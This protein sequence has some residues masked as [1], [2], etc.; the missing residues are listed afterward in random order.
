MGKLDY[1][2]V[3]TNAVGEPANPGLIS[4][5]AICGV[6]SLLVGAITFEVWRESQLYR[7]SGE[8][9]ASLLLVVARPIAS[10]VEVLLLGFYLAFVSTPK[11]IGWVGIVSGV[12][13]G[14][15]IVAITLTW[16]F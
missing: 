4:L 13:T 7:H 8:N 1:R 3:R 10:L 15:A 2:R 16:I 5:T 14:L 6:L 12:F 9:Y 11:R